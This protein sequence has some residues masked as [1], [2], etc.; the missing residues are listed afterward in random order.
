M[1]PFDIQA[2]AFRPTIDAGCRDPAER[3]ALHAALDG[4]LAAARDVWGVLVVTPPDEL[5]RCVAVPPS[6]PVLAVADR[7]RGHAVVSPVLLLG[8]S[9][10]RLRELRDMDA[11][12]HAAGVPLWA[13]LAK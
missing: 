12:A 1:D 5:P 6:G 11:G 3:E 2:A 8:F 4:A 7:Q 13:G 10:R 9:P